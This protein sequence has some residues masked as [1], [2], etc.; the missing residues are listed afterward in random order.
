[1]T[2]YV[3]SSAFVTRYAPDESHH[4][5]CVARM[6]EDPEWATSRL[7]LVEAPRG[8]HRHPD[9]AVARTGLLNFDADA[10][11]TAMINI[12]HGVIAHARAIAIETGIKTLDAIHIASAH[13]FPTDELEFLTYDERQAAV[14][15]DLGLR[16]A[17]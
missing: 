5:D 14:A 8:I 2:L 6:D 17:R 7:T 1:M 3:D 9:P 4:R 12:D 11:E 16:L 15:E 10:Q 13:Q